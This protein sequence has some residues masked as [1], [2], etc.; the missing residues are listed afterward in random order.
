MVR[1]TQVF[2]RN[3][4]PIYRSQPHYVDYCWLIR[5]PAVS[6]QPSGAATLPFPDAERQS[7]SDAA[8][9]PRKRKRQPG[10]LGRGLGRILND[11]GNE[12]AP[13]EIQRSG[14]LQLVGG[15]VAT[16]PDRIREVVVDAALGAMMAGF[17]LDGVVLVAQAP[18]TPGSAAGDRPDRVDRL[19]SP[20]SSDAAAP[21]DGADADPTFLAA[22]LPPSWSADSQLLFEM[23]G[24]LWWLLRDPDEADLAAGADTSGR[25]PVGAAADTTQWQ[26]PLGRNW[27]WMCRM[28]DGQDV[29]AAVAIRQTRFEAAEADTLSSLVNATVVACS[30]SESR[31]AMRARIAKGT[32]TTLKSDGDEIQAEVVAEWHQPVER[33]AGKNNGGGD[34]GAAARRIGAARA[35]DAPTAVARA[36]A[37]ACR[38]RCE[39]T[40]AGA[41]EVD[42][43]SEVSIVMIDGP[44]HGLRMGFA[45]R[46]RGDRGGAA[47]AVFTAA[48]G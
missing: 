48:L 13:T 14:L 22:K 35:A 36:A 41:S 4:S 10:G 16:G 47:E 43:E 23:Y 11:S 21:A 5:R 44:E 6:P 2:S 31:L 20:G 46:E 40:F 27:L 32:R 25:E 8:R 12:G 24:N 38:P 33:T 34:S 17:G 26:L 30:N 29:V 28:M 1:E 15:E 9:R 39:V 19:D 37:K 3:T 45:V 18:V 7:G 42:E